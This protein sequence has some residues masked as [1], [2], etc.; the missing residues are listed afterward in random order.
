M[1]DP[2][3]GLLPQLV[4]VLSALADSQEL[5][6]NRIRT[7]HLELV[8]IHLTDGAGSWRALPLNPGG[9]T[10]LPVVATAHIPAPEVGELFTPDRNRL[11]TQSSTDPGVSVS[12]RDI[13]GWCVILNDPEVVAPP[14]M[15]T[16]ITTSVHQHDVAQQATPSQADDLRVTRRNDTTIESGDRRYNFFDELDAQLADLGTAENGSEETGS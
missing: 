12:N 16:E 6:T 10:E 1:T 2:S 5:L 4:E 8:S 9:P 3:K 15:A 13:E 7:A 14:N 11:S